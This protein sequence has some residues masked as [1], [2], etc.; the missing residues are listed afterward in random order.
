VGKGTTSVWKRRNERQ[1]VVLRRLLGWGAVV[2]LAAGLVAQA[3]VTGD[4]VGAAP[5]WLVRLA[6]V[7]PG[8]IFLTWLLASR[9]LL[10]DE[11]GESAVRATVDSEER[12]ERLERTF[13]SAA[14]PRARR[15][16]IDSASEVRRSEYRQSIGVRPDDGNVAPRASFGLP[17]HGDAARD[18]LRDAR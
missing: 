10:F 4:G 14:V 6:L 13:D 12:L 7:L 1:R 18:N 5:E 16:S 15:A 8:V 11:P 2:G 9:S 17:V 3:A